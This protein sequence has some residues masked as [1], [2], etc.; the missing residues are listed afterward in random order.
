[1][2]PSQILSVQAKE[3]RDQKINDEAI[4]WRWVVTQSLDPF[5]PAVNSPCYSIITHS[6]PLAKE[7]YRL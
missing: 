6:A 4:I 7:S 2:S 3:T 5:Q 1:M